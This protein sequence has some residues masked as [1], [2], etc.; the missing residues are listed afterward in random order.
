MQE[1]DQAPRREGRW[2]VVLT[3]IVTV[4]LL[5]MLPDRLRMVP[6]ALPLL[7]AAAVLIPLIAV[8]L[9]HAS[10]R[11]LRLEH[12]LTLAFFGV[13][14]LGT[15][16]NLGNLIRAMVHRPEDISGLALL[17]SSIGVWIT[18][19]L[20]FSLLYWQ[21]DRGGPGPRALNAATLPDWQFPQSAATD[22]VPPG[23]RPLFVDYLFLGF[24][25]A[26]AFSMTEALPLTPRAKL[27]MMLEST[28]AL[29]TVVVVASRAINI[30]GS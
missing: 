24:S 23:W 7:L 11:W 25:T 21:I 12:T 3:V 13:A 30:L 22:E 14:L 29:V 17:S 10:A 28:I 8:G 26:T 16:A 27:L 4:F 6:N 15:L 19:V 5:A 1:L 18:N 2:P 9:T 20:M